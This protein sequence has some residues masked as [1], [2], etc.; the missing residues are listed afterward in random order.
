MRGGALGCVT[1][2]TQPVVWLRVLLAT[3]SHKVNMVVTG[4][5]Y[6]VKESGNGEKTKNHKIYMEAVYVGWWVLCC[7]TVA[8]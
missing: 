1:F 4:F 7:V 3:D 8:C 2:V 6:K 5:P